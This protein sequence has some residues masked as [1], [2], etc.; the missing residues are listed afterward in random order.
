MRGCT[1]TT[2]RLIRMLIGVVALSV[3]VTHAAGIGAG[4]AYVADAV[5]VIGLA[6]GII[7]RCPLYA[8]L[9]VQT[10]RRPA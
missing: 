10:C 4:W 1:G 7:G 9:G 2:D 5:G 3:G 6:T 8:V